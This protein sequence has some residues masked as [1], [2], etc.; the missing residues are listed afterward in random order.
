[1]GLCEVDYARPLVVA[2][3]CEAG[4][5][6]GD[7]FLLGQIVVELVDNVPALL[8]A[9]LVRVGLLT[10]RRCCNHVDLLLLL[11]FLNLCHSLFCFILIMSVLF[12]QF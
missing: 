7:V 2:L 9:G 12:F 8:C 3:R 11:E 6:L 1:M 10:D 4:V 5:P